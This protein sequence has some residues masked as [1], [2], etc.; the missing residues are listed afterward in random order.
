MGIL[1]SAS[2][3]LPGPAG[4]GVEDGAVL[5]DDDRFAAVGYRS[6]VEARAP[7]G[8][9]RHHFPGGTILP[10]LINAH[11]HLAFHGGSDAGAVLQAQH[12]GA[13]LMSQMIER[14]AT[15][16]FSGVTTARDLGDRS[17]LALRVRDAIAVG[18]TVG[19]R[20]LTA[21][22][23]LT[24]P[25]G[26]CWFLG[27]VVHGEAD[28]R[29][30]IDRIAAAGG[31]AIKIMASGGQTTPD[32]FAM[33]D[34]QFTEAQLRATVDHAHGHGLPVAAHAHAADS[35]AAAVNAGV[36][37][38][39]HGS[40]LTPGPSW[41][42][43]PDVAEQM[44]AQ[45]TVLCH[46]SSNNWRTFARVA[47]D[48]WARDLTA[49]IAWFDQHGVDQIAGTDAGINRF[50]ESP[51]ALARFADYGF[52]PDRIIEIGT[53]AGARALGLANTTGT[54]R[55]GLAADLLV[56]DG[57][58]STDIT[59]LQHTRLVIARGTPHW[60]HKRLFSDQA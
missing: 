4:E 20:L 58:A 59:A 31:D 57:D 33:W 29:S 49:R 56:I 41:N 16:L 35:I 8:A 3:M 17:G 47:G 43:R 21:T 46:A 2:R 45:G 18:E 54:L 15:L 1:V 28:I 36:D 13:E 24:P 38:I 26:H 25:G 53:V 37:S 6:E 44:A 32:G 27:G 14:A 50:T 52:P 48:Q 40:W 55:P 12:D 30:R 60:P 42:P 10:G 39:E 7:A 34:C 23:P 51:A 11:V 19:P 9:A 5:V 22:S